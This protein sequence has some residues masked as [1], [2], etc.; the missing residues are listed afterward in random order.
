VPTFDPADL[1]DVVAVTELQPLDQLPQRLEE[2][3]RILAWYY[4]ES[5]IAVQLR[6]L[7]EG[8]D[9]SVPETPVQ[10]LR[11][12]REKRPAQRMIAVKSW[13]EDLQEAQRATA[14][15]R[16]LFGEAATADEA[17]LR[18]ARF[19]TAVVGEVLEVLA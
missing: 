19:A 16:D 12:V 14:M 17:A 6:R 13:L 2:V 5:E 4:G 8:E 3:A 18:L 7:A 15:T 9:E 10:I 1:P 11:I